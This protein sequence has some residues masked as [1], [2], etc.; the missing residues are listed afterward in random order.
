MKHVETPGGKDSL[1]YTFETSGGHAR[2]AL[3]GAIDENA[4]LAGLFHRV[5]TDTVMN[6]RNVERV[7]SMGVHGWVPLI[8]K[9]SARHRL[10]MEE[11]SY[12]LVQSANA[13][14]NMFGSA[15][16]RSCIAP[17]FCA[18]CKQNVNVT[19]TADEVAAARDS[20]PTKHCAAC[21]GVLEFDELDGYF[22]FF[23]ARARK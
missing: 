1:K 8:N 15:V 5:V 3:A 20:V 17:Y 12:A 18:R 19:V 9:V 4:D 7:N 21:Q 23:K 6:L 11:L 16:L 22:A 14:A 2:V 10:A 13:V